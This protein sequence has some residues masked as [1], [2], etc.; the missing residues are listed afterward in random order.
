MCACVLE[1][2]AREE[3]GQSHRTIVGTNIYIEIRRF[4]F[5]PGIME[6]R[7]KSRKRTETGNVFIESELSKIK[8]SYK[9]DKIK[10]YLNKEKHMKTIKTMQIKSNKN[11]LHDYSC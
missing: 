5:S 1:D 2:I 3:E 6:H 4:D 9:N 7:V 10:R 11:L 8:L